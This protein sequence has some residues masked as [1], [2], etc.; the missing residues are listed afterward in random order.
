MPFYEYECENCKFYTEL[1]QKVTDAPLKKC[2]SCGK[3]TMKKLVSAPVF[4]L[5][6]GGWYETDF[7]GDKENKRNLAVDK[8]PDTA[9]DSKPAKSGAAAD[10]KAADSTKSDA[11][12]AEAKSADNG[13]SGSGSAGG[14]SSSGSSS[15]GSS[16]GSGSRKASTSRA[17]APK[18]RAKPAAKGKASKAKRR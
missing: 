8:E 16:S 6:G 4:R 18:S 2:P 10:T 5:K 13:S 7:K 14:S 1:L 17:A 15:R 11:K 12:P 9:S 3:N